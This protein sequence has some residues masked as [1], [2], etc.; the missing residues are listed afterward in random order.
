MLVQKKTIKKLIANFAYIY[1]LLSHISI[2]THKMDQFFQYKNILWGLYSR[3]T[4]ENQ[5][6]DFDCFIKIDSKTKIF[7][8]L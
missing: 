7:F 1:N 2:E 6:W 3:E 8:T 5:L 4:T